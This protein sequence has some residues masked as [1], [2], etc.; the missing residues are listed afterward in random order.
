MNDTSKK[1]GG[2]AFIN[3][4]E[5]ERT[6]RILKSLICAPAGEELMSK[7]VVACEAE[8]KSGGIHRETVSVIEK[9]SP[10]EVSNDLISKWAG[11]MDVAGW[12]ETE[13]RLGKLTPAEMSD[14]SK[15]RC[16]VAMD[17][18]SS[19]SHV[20]SRS[21][22]GAE[23]KSRRPYRFAG[24]AAS[25][26]FLLVSV[27]VA[28]QYSKNEMGEADGVVPKQLAGISSA[29]LNRQV[30]RVVEKG[31]NWSNEQGQR[32]C[33]VDFEDSVEMTDEKGH[34]VVVSVPK[35]RKV[36]VPVQVY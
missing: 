27:F 10:L 31:V 1:D 20:P 15:M 22:G 11:L 21:L 17:L 9:V 19:E 8:R 12:K 35:T 18:V 29:E 34:R 3:S 33:D 14:F 13:K 32:E 4:E 23:R 26:T 30:V 28:M 36:V 2:D 24:I 7:F 5:D 6:E 16:S 25:L